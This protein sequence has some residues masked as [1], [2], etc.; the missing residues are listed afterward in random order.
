L[1]KVGKGGGDKI[2]DAT[3]EGLLKRGLETVS[4]AP[5]DRR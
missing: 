1:V 3:M 5:L 4:G 2:D